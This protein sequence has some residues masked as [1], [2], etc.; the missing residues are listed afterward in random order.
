MNH[1]DDTNGKPDFESNLIQCVNVS[2]WESPLETSNC[3]NTLGV[4]KDDIALDLNQE[5]CHLKI[6]GVCMLKYDASFSCK[7]TFVNNPPNSYKNSSKEEHDQKVILFDRKLRE[8]NIK[9]KNP[10]LCS[11]PLFA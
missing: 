3:V 6:P 5:N 1:N 4:D 8:Y 11:I 2:Q 7:E 9:K 10:A